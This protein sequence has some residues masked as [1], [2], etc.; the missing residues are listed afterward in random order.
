MNLKNEFQ[1]LRAQNKR[2]AVSFYCGQYRELCKRKPELLMEERKCLNCGAKL[3]NEDV[4]K[5]KKEDGSWEE[6]PLSICPDCF[7]EQM[8]KQAGQRAAR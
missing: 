5:I 2:V 3:T 7:T 6:I 4:M 8:R 1:H